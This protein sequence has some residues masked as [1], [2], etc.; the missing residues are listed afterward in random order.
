MS[1][2]TFAKAELRKLDA[3]FKN[4]V[5]PDRWVT[6][7]FNP[8]TLK[9]S[10]ANQLI[11]SNGGGDQKGGAARQFVG[12]GTMKLAAQLWFDVTT[13][14]EGAPVVQDVRQLTRKV[15]WFITPHEEAGQQ[16]PPVVRFVWGSFQFDGLMDSLEES[17]ELFSPEGRPLR[18]SVAFTLSQQKIAA[19]VIRQA[20]A[21]PPG[22]GARAA[23]TTPL[24]AAP[25]GATLQALAAG[26]GQAA[27]WKDIATANGIEDPRR[28]RPGQLVDLTLGR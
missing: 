3:D 1:P 12:A 27:A 2:R 14:E 24:T 6:V 18:A 13:R 9:V 4:E 19:F 26:A 8:E 20:A 7:Q 21:P 25:E 23:G 22:A 15:A 17:L 5:E 10:L 28:L 16:V 11:T